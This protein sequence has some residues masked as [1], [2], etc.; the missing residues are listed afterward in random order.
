I[1]CENNLHQVG[2]AMHGYH[3]AYGQFPVEGTT[4]GIS[5]PLKIMPYIEQGN[6]YNKV[7]PLF[8]GAYNHDLAAYPYSATPPNDRATLVAEAGAAASQVDASMTVPIFLCPSRRAGNPGPYIDYCGAY[9]GGIHQGELTEPPNSVNASGYN[10]ILDT[11]I[12]GPRTQG[13]SMSVVT[14]G[15]GT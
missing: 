7:W 11:Y 4:Q 2:L 8:Q 6:V 14:N 12:T 1:K 3:D 13:V 5:W 10:A 9:H 15:A